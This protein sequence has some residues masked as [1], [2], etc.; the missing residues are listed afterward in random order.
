MRNIT[1]TGVNWVQKQTKPCSSLNHRKGQPC[2]TE[3][4]TFHNQNKY[5][6]LYKA[7]VFAVLELKSTGQ[8]VKKGGLNAAEW[9]K[10]PCQVL[11]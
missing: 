3:D 8:I 11:L 4:L 7:N 10:N 2:H 5:N 1:K 6:S 9:A